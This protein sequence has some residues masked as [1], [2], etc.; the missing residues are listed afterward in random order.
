MQKWKVNLLRF[1]PQKDM[2]TIMKKR[3]IAIIAS[4]AIL[5]LLTGCG[6]R[7]TPEQESPKAEYT[8]ITP[9]EAILMMSDDGDV[10]I[11]DVRTEEEYNSGHIQNAIL[12]PHDEIR[13]RAEKE[14]PDKNQVVLVYCRSGARSETAA[15]E[16]ID[17]GYTNVYDFG[18]IIDWPYEVVQ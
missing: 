12:I 7:Q 14:L 3:K 2:V 4:F 15:R 5:L 18:G 8:R 13:E 17:M 11:L 9:E 1:V 10:V 16:L 6:A